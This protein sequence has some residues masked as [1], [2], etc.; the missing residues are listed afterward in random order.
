M[1]LK[2]KNMY[3]IAA[4]SLF[5]CMVITLVRKGD[6]NTFSTWSIIAGIILMV[7]GVGFQPARPGMPTVGQGFNPISTQIA[8]QIA[9]SEGSR[10]TNKT[11]QPFVDGGL[12]CLILGVLLKIIF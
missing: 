9:S 2:N 10:R 1:K 6:I 4:V 12:I 8:E 3:L 5:V 7:M 11:D